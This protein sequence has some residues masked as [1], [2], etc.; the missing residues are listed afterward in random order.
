MLIR[1]TLR[2]NNQG[3][4]PYTS[5]LNSGMAKI[6]V[7]D[8]APDLRDNVV[9]LLK[10]DK[11][12]VDEAERASDAL[13][14]M[15]K[16]EYD[17]LVLD[18]ELPD[19]SGVELCRHYRETGGSGGVLV[20]SGRTSAHDKSDAL[21]AGADD[22]VTKPY[23]VRELRSRVNA[24]LRRTSGAASGRRTDQTTKPALINYTGSLLGNS[25]LIHEMIGKGGMGVVYRAE[26]IHLKRPVAVKVL[27]KNNVLDERDL[28]RF[29]LEAQITAG[30][31]HSSLV[32]VYDFGFTED[33]SPFIVME[34]LQGKTLAEILREA[35][36]VYHLT[37]TCIFVQLCDALSHA[38]NS[39][40]VHR[41][42][43]PSNVMISGSPQSPN[44]KL[45]DLG[46]SK[47][48]Q[49]TE[50]QE[51]LTMRGEI[52]GSPLYMSPEQWLTRPVDERS[53]MYSMGCLIYETLTGEVPF[54]GSGFMDTGF[55]HMN[56]FP[57]LLREICPEA[58]IPAALEDITL[59]LLAKN[60]DHRVQ[61]MVELKQMLLAVPREA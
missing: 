51:D 3:E 58:N 47:L 17:L 57:R 48:L 26:H 35:G 49:P 44:V 41:D 42:I 38:H 12:V 15:G 27:N 43:K 36:R 29:K 34:Y 32:H 1:K 11:H 45:L 20:V 25:Y 39:K 60:P 9:V 23:S 10:L 19:M 24:L 33:G 52:F 6:L 14:L 7:V 55:K 4:A 53:D 54:K 40:L 61:S 31:S 5:Y 21:D 2:W 46:L 18:W 28:R 37:A 50:D 56:E 59:K 13:A 22:Y 16:A 8:D 30:L